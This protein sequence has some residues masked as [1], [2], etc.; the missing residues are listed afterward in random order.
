ML[1]RLAQLYMHSLISIS[2]VVG[3]G[4][5]V[6]NHGGLFNEQHVLPWMHDSLPYHG[7]GEARGVMCTLII[8]THTHTRTYTLGY[9]LCQSLYC[10][11]GQ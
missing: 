8:Y 11:L 3:I 7:D 2:S 1:A 10:D 5:V 9:S 6:V 4:S